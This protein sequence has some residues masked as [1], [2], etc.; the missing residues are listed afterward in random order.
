MSDTENTPGVLVGAEPMSHVAGSSTGVVVL[1]GFTGNPSSVRHLATA[2]ADAEYDV[3]M[4][5]LPGH[6]TTVDDMMTT[7]WDDWF[8]TALDAADAVAARCDKV[9]VAGLSM[10]GLLTLAVGMER[11]VAALVCVNPV[12]RMRSPEETAMVEE[13][14]A[15]GMT[16]LP[17]IGSD[18]ADPDVV[19]IA[20]EGTPLQPLWSMFHE[21]VKPRC[22][23]W[24]SST[25]PLL[26]FTSSQDH[27]V[28][29]AD[30]VHLATTHGGPVEHVWLER[31]FHV[32]T[33]DYD[34][35]LI[36]ERTLA[37]LATV[38]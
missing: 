36:C 31:S 21:G 9:V 8:A 13:L 35:D 22:D 34:R 15:D 19:E 3:E 27:V 33:Q 30:S 1:H 11:D 17:G 12:A 4:P 20:Y 25:A 24:G 32:A 23:N 6:G 5:R 14:I 29:P 2:I 26:L 16:V 37:F 10:G 7:S 28:D 18:I 38:S